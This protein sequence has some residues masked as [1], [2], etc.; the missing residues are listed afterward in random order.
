MNDNKDRQGVQ[1]RFMDGSV[2]AGPCKYLEIEEFNSKVKM[3]SNSFTTLSLNIRSLTGKLTEF[4]DF[5]S[6]LH[7]DNFKINVVGLQ[8]LWN[9]PPNLNTNI[10]GFHPL[11]CKLRN[12]SCS[13]SRNNIGGGVGFYISTDLD[14]EIIDNLTQSCN[15]LF[16]SLFLKIKTK[17]DKFKII[18]NIYRK[19]GTD[20]KEFNDRLE[21]MLDW[22]FKD[23]TL[24]R[25]DE[26]QILGDFNFDLL[27]HDKDISTSI[28]LDTMLNFGLLPLI[29]LPTRLTAYSSTLLDNVF[30]NKSQ[31]LSFDS[32]LLYSY[33]SDHLP[34]FTISHELLPSKNESKMSRNMS[35]ENIG[36]FKNHLACTEWSEIF[37]QNNPKDSFSIFENKMN[38]LFEKSFPLEKEKINKNNVPIEPW[39]TRALLVSRRTKNILARN[40]IKRPTPANISKYKTFFSIYRAALR[41]AKVNYYKS[42]FQDYANDIKKTWTTIRELLGSCSKKGRAIPDIFVDGGK[43]YNGYSEITEGFNEFFSNVGSKL[44][45]K[46]P[47]STVNF[48]DFLPNQT[49]DKFVFANI[50]EDMILDTTRKLKSKRSQGLDNISSY[51]LKEIMP[52][53]VIQITYLFNVSIRSGYVP[54]SYKC[55]KIIPIFKSGDKSQFTNYRPISLLSSFSKLLEKIIAK[56]MIRYLNKFEILYPHQYGFRPGYSTTQ[57]LIQFLDRIYSGLNKDVPEY[58]L[59]IFLDLKKAFDT[60]DHN[61]LLKK[62]YNYGFKGESYDWFK[63]YLSNRTQ[64]VSI[65]GVNSSI[66][67]IS[68]GVPQGSVLGPIL[69]LLYINDMPRCTTLFTSLFADDT[70]L[71]TSS[72]DLNDLIQQTNSELSKVATWFTA[73]KLTLNVS[74]T[75]YLI[76]RTKKMPISHLYT[77]LQIGG[78]IIERVGE[79]CRE[80]TFKFVGLN[81]DEYVTWQSHVNTICKKSFIGKF[82]AKFC[83]KFLAP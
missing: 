23:N 26:I 69:F 57:P 78:E 32:G 45:D 71:F 34:I 64:Y 62:L 4:K 25:A 29:S 72:P 28:F 24:K 10:N 61:I 35:K 20:A 44:A 14:F 63:S 37:T 73:N 15:Q 49:Q 13:T 19:P 48:K 75:K 6:E 11:V 30:S 77:D 7:Q 39:M 66:K 31:Q 18:G 36:K 5:I 33:I 65:E 42:K 47:P 12:G 82:C 46:I 76:F 79:G 80:E 40:R 50:T 22:I 1:S 3:V 83:E 53:I 38:I 51:L 27:K 60:T 54:D 56:Q 81:L 43:A 68:C 2:I 21:K 55:A 58:T 9:I 70:G 41:K 52:I 17:K 67:T 74:K 59:G 16:E 8:E